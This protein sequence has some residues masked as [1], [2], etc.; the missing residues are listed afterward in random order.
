MGIAVTQGPGYLTAQ[1]ASVDVGRVAAEQQ[2]VLTDLRSVEGGLEDLFLELTSD[3]QREERSPQP[4]M[5]AP[6]Q[7][8]PAGFPPP[9]NDP[10]GAAR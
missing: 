8:P 5:P 9:S 3:T 2:L 10:T 1:C 4:T 7:A 6:P